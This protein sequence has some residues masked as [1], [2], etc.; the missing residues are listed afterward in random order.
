LRRID[1]LKQA[2][3]KFLN[4]SDRTVYKWK[5]ENRPIINFL[6]TYFQKNDL[7]EYIETG[8]MKKLEV[9]QQMSN[10]SKYEM[11]LMSRILESVEE[12]TITHKV[13]REGF[14]IKL[15]RTV[16]DYGGD[17]NKYVNFLDNYDMKSWESLR[18]VI[19]GSS[20]DDVK[21]FFLD[22]LSKKEQEILFSKKFH[23]LPPLKSMRKH[24][25]HL[26]D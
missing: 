4:I 19:W 11:T 9:L 3:S 23:I 1:I 14:L 7:Y 25:A 22:Y 26:K 5:T 20:L 15:Y 2:V 18:N 10:V 6:Y 8:K 13:N 17:T 16:R 21:E 12:Y 24:N